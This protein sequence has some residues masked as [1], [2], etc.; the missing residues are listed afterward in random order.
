MTRRSRKSKKRVNKRPTSPTVVSPSRKPAETTPLPPGI[1]K[2]DPDKTVISLKGIFIEAPAGFCFNIL[3]K[4][5]EKPPQ[6]DPMIVHAWPASNVRNKI[7]ATSQVILD[8][9]GKKVESKAMM[10]RYHPERAISWVLSEKPKVREDWQLERKPHGTQ[11]RV[12]LAHEL[13][14]WVIGRLIYKIIRRKRVE[15]DL[16]KMLAQLKQAVESTSRDQRT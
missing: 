5:L 8:L 2:L 4:Q 9:G 3:S 16:D 1:A 6:W 13:D 12:A 7:G 10:S 15:Q 11:V 14:G